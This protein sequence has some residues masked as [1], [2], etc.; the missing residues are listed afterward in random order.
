MNDGMMMQPPQQGV[1]PTHP[2]TI[3][4]E[5]QQWNG[6]MATLVKG[7]YEQVAPLIQLIAQ[8]LQQ[9]QATLGPPNGSGLPV[10]PPPPAMN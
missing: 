9:Q 4:L 6:V 5:A 3:T 7:P 1:S 2:F 8:Q 10:E